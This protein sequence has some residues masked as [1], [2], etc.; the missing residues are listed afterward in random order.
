MESRN[1]VSA[2]VSRSVC[3][4]LR[5]LFALLVAVVAMQSAASAQTTIWS[6]STTPAVLADADQI[7][8]EL[9]VKFRSSTP[10]SISA[11]R[12]FKSTTN[13]GPHVVKLYTG[14]GT[15]L[16]SVNASGT[17]GSGWQQI[18]LAQPV[19]IAANTTYVA[20]YYTASGRY[21]VNENYFTA[22]VTNGP[23][24]AL[25]SGVEGGNGDYRYG[26]GGGFP[27]ESFRASNYWVDVVFTA[28]TT[29]A[30]ATTTT[31]ASSRN[32]SNTGDAVTFTATVAAVPPAAGTPAG[33]VQ[34]RVNGS[35]F[36]AP[37]SLSNGSA[38][39]AATS[40]LTAGNHNVDALYAGSA[41]F[42]PSAS[43]VLVQTVQT[44]SSC[45]GND[46]VV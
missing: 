46:I 20:S 7:P 27:A 42:S 5:A 10:G 21:S 44:Q 8:V 26:T 4:F 39:S 24:T 14:T 28:S 23:L 45:T 25:A 19:Q 34:F 18:A 30:A 6:S 16:V 9:G 13:V 41:G 38:T 32:P 22:S 40:T 1:E 37:V 12:F 15:L 3:G 17:T 43:S 33:T 2:E 31:V 29:G 35:N 36:G 11:I